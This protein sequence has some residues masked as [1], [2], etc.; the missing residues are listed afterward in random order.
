HIW[1]GTRGLVFLPDGFDSGNPHPL[2]IYN[3]EYIIP[4]HEMPLL[5]AFRP[6]D[7]VVQPWVKMDRLTPTGRTVTVDGE[8]CGEYEAPVATDHVYRL[9]L[10]PRREYLPV[11]IQR[12]NRGTI[13]SSTT[14]T[15]QQFAKNAWAPVRWVTERPGDT[16]VAT[17]TAEVLSLRIN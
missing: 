14:I 3:N 7:R 5:V 6:L 8:A 2:A 1:D 11:L 13:D 17:R 4:P 16:G 15:Y 12:V 10:R 9:L